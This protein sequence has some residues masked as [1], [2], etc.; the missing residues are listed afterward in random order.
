MVD[1]TVVDSRLVFE[2]EELVDVGVVSMDEA[3]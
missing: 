1:P 2:V 3:F